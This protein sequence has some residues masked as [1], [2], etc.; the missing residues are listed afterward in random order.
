[1]IVTLF[2]VG[3]PSP[4]P[5]KGHRVIRRLSTLFVCTALLTGIAV[6]SPVSDSNEQASPH[7]WNNNSA[8]AYWTP[9]RMA[10]ALPDGSGTATHFPGIATIGVLFSMGVGMKAHFCTAGVVHS[11]QHDLLLTAGHCRHG[12]DTAFVPKYTKGAKRQPYG[13]WAVGRVYR[14][15]RWSLTGKG[16]DY[17]FAFVKVKPDA[18][19]RRIEDVTGANRL[20]RTPSWRNT[21]TVVGY[22]ND[23]NDADPGN[24]P[25]ACT[26][27]TSRLSEDLNQMRIDC[28]GFYGGTSGSPWL[29]DYDPRT[30][31]GEIVGLIGGE[32][33]G[34]PNARISYSPCFDNAIQQLYARATA[35]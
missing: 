35:A 16:S 6:W 24:R 5:G 19:G 20:A 1:M 8:V 21:V 33:G 34:G 18:D 25:I 12:S 31:T 29:I 30:G 14:D 27:T 10:A 4:R 26:T 3:W 7:S 28:G 9:G 11:P 23:G 32:G 2:W 15:S 17:D 22:P 13:V